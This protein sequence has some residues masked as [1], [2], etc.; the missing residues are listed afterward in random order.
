[1]NLSRYAVVLATQWGI[2]IMLAMNQL[3]IPSF[4]TMFAYIPTK[5]LQFFHYFIVSLF[6][7]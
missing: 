1:M 6:M 2:L 7:V 4:L 3:C 5:V